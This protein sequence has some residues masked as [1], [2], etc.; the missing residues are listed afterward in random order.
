M[1]IL[2]LDLT[3]PLKPACV[4]GSRPE[5]FALTKR[6]Y[7]VGMLGFTARPKA[8]N[9]VFTVGKDADQGR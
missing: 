6:M 4:A 1:D 3:L 5:Y 2:A 7:A 9:G 8:V